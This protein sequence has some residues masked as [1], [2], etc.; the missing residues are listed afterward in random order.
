M[1][2][3]CTQ[4]IQIDTSHTHTNTHTHTHTYTHIYTPKCAREGGMEGKRSLL[5]EGSVQF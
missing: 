3:L 2:F 1:A 4:V 5:Q